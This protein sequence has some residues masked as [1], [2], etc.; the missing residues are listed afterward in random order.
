MRRHLVIRA[1]LAL[2]MLVGLVFS[3]LTHAAAQVDDVPYEDAGMPLAEIEALFPLVF[4]TS[5]RVDPRSGMPPVWRAYARDAATGEERMAGFIFL[6]SDIPPEEKGYTAPIEVLIGMD[7]HGKITGARVIKYL[8]S[9]RSSRGDFLRGSYEEQF[10]GKRMSDRFMVRRDIET[11]SG[12]TIT[13]AAAARGIRNAARRVFGAY[14]VEQSAELTRGEIDRLTW[15]E[16]EM[17]GFTDRLIGVDGATLEILVSLAPI[18]DSAMGELFLGDAYYRALDRLGRNR[19][20][21]RKQWVVGLDGQRMM[22]FRGPQLYALRGQDTLRF[23][24]ADLVVL[25]D[26]RTGKLAGHYRSTGVLL[27]DPSLSE[28]DNFTWEIDLGVGTPIYRVE[29]VGDPAP[30]AV[31]RAPA[32]TANGAGTTSGAVD[33]STPG[34][35][36]ATGQGSTATQGATAAAPAERAGQ[37]A[38]AVPLPDVAFDP[39]LH[40]DLFDFEQ[41]S[42]SVLAR[43]LEMTSWPLAGLMAGMLALTSAAFFAKIVWL[44][45]VTLA[46][47]LGFLGFGGGSF[48]SV[49]HIT[50]AIRVGP[51]I[52]L[53]D[54]PL[55]LLVVFTVITTLLWGRVFC[56][57]LCPFGALQDFM[58]HIVPKKIRRKFPRPVHENGQ[59]V[60]YGVLGVILLPAIAGSEISIF[61]YFE[62]FGTVF[63]WSRSTVLWVIAGALMVASAIIPRFYCRYV[64]PLG[65]S[66][67]LAST[68]S[69]FRIKRV[70]HC[71]FC[72]VCE[73]SCPTGAIRRET[74]DFRE[75]VRCNIC[76]VKLRQAAGVCGHELEK[77]SRLIEI[78]RGGCRLPQPESAGD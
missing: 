72:T 44:R 32:E 45:W 48:L 8:E 69:P 27:S 76:E 29:H 46:F 75:C 9:L 5:T 3:D 12:A 21:D 50:A 42:Q 30:I 38:E 13:A 24:M 22:F 49:S 58:E 23:Q 26:P 40:T 6:T 19:A 10:T 16:L 41:E 25:G 63:F 15:P 62:P 7:I 60:K 56:G 4:P 67:A 18:A 36:S 51:S 17:R 66:L 77:V 33:G 34:V 70:P 14:M 31:E 53:Q 47:T 43:T 2:G 52:F 74:V 39:S 54:I 55:L 68:I 1:F 20:R 59:Y 37:P 73:Q 35:D 28:D 57:Y 11:V 71:T 65:A 64:C 61:Q 78:K